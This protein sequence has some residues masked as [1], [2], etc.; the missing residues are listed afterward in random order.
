MYREVAAVVVEGCPQVEFDRS[1]GVLKLA[2]LV[3]RADRA[4]ISDIDMTLANILRTAQL[5]PVTRQTS[6]GMLRHQ[7]F[8]DA[9]SQLAH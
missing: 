5:D 6:V 2:S 8:D 3:L 9:A 1:D 4:S 7:Q